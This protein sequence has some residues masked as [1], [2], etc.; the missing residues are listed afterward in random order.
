MTSVVARAR[1]KAPP[2]SALWT[3]R[4]RLFGLLEGPPLVALIAGPG[5]DKT[6]L[7]AAWVAEQSLEPA[8][9]SVAEGDDEPYLL[10]AHL[11]AALGV[12][13]G[14]STGRAALDRALNALVGRPTVL[15][16]DDVHRLVNP[17]ALRLLNYVLDYLPEGS[18]A[19]LAG[20]ERPRMAGWSTW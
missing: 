7:L 19:V 4:P 17:E 14:E 12:D 1:L 11:C 10:V 8:W 3:R 16:V 18:R 6:H 13:P 5:Y 20:R 15:I 2:V 9:Y